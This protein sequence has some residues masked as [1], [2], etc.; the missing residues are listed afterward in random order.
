MPEMRKIVK[1]D[2]VP[3]EYEVLK[4]LGEYGGYE[5]HGRKYN[6]KGIVGLVEAVRHGRHSIEL[7]FDSPALA[8]E[9]T[10]LLNRKYAERR[11]KKNLW[12]SENKEPPPNKQKTCN[13]NPYKFVKF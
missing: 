13:P 10:D 1:L 3:S 9:L 5:K 8:K 2:S 7:I 6:L 12:N 4:P 11:I